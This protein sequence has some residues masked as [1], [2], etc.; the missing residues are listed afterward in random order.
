MI[1]LCSEGPIFR[2]SYL[3]KVLCSENI[4][5]EGPMFK[6]SHIQKILC[7]KDP[8]FRN[9]CLEGSIAYSCGVF[10]A[11]ALFLNT[12]HSENRSF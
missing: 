7:S 6:W 2:R 1:A 11:V 12:G 8:I 3:Q 4:C 9:I 10:C 5:S